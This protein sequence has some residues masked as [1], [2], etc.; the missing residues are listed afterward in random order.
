MSM[1]E[2]TLTERTEPLTLEEVF[3]FID[4]TNI[5]KRDAH[6]LKCRIV[7]VVHNTRN[8]A[9]DEFV[10]EAMKMFTD[11]DLK[12]GYPTVA[13]CKIILRDVAEQMKGGRKVVERMG[14]YIDC[15]DCKHCISK[16]EHYD[17]VPKFFSTS[18][19]FYCTK[20]NNKYLGRM[21]AENGDDGHRECFEKR[22]AEV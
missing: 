14:K 12:H 2:L 7:D 5:S 10:E 3:D 20:Y 13:D 22:E 17:N 21:V 1:V 16:M 19:N 9:I 18:L 8:K 15:I 6:E 11:F 4:D